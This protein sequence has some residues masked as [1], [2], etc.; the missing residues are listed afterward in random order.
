MHI[1][2]ASTLATAIIAAVATVALL[3]LPAAAN[4]VAVTITSGTLTLKTPAG[5]VIDDIDLASPGSACAGGV[6]SMTTAG[7][8]S[9]GT[10]GATLRWDDAV[11]VNGQSFV[12]NMTMTLSGTYVLPVGTYG[13]SGTGTATAVFVRSTGLGSCTKS[14]GAGSCTVTA[15]NIGWTGTLFAANAATLVAGDSA[16]LAGG[17]APP[18]TAV[19]GTATNCGTLTPLNGGSVVL[20]GL[21]LAV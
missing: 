10:V 14:G 2:R 18:F 13:V 17:N 11:T 9:T 21:D 16:S 5:A 8:P 12:M 1:R 3:S 15:A 6:S 20:S 4:T 7:S 19:S